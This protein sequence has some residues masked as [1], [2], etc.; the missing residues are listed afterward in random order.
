MVHFAVWIASFLIVNM[1]GTSRPWAAQGMP[2]RPLCGHL[3]PQGGR[4]AKLLKRFF[5]GVAFVADQL[6]FRDFWVT[7]LRA[8]R[9]FCRARLTFHPI[10]APDGTGML[11]IRDLA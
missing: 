5:G 1:I 2:I 10:A 3:L 8:S 4:A 11:F 6:Y 9:E 7:R